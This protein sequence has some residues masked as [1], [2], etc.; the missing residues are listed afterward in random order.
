M[1][2]ILFTIL[3]ASILITSSA[4]AY[5]VKQGDT[6]SSIAEDF[7]TSWQS[8]W[9]SNPEIANPD[10]IFIGQN[11]NIPTEQTLG[12]SIPG[13]AALFE[14]SLQNSISSSATTMTLVSGTLKNSNTLSG[15][16]GFI[17]DEGS[18]NQEFVTATCSNTACTGMTRGI[19]PVTGD[20]AV[21]ALQSSH[22]RGA[23][24]KITDFPVLG[25]IRRI[26]NGDETLP[27]SLHAS[28]TTWLATN[29][30][31]LTTKYYVDN[32]GAGGFTNSNIGD[33]LTLRA[34][35]TSPETLDLNTTTDSLIAPSFT[36]ENGYLV[37]A[38]S[39]GS[40]IDNQI[41]DRM[42]ATTTKNLVFTFNDGFQ[43]NASSTIIGNF[44][45]DGN[46]TVTGQLNRLDFNDSSTTIVSSAAETT[47][48]TKSI[49]A[50]TLKT[51]NGVRLKGLITIGA[52]TGSPTLTLRLKY[53]GTTMVTIVI[54]KAAHTGD[55]GWIEANVFGDGSV[56]AQSAN[57]QYYYKE[58]TDDY[59]SWGN[60]S[61]TENSASD[62]NLVLTGQWNGSDPSN[63]ISFIH[64]SL[65]IIR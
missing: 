31:E 16:Y 48:Y 27:F 61:A 59:Y 8:I 23:S 43:S 13:V 41:S 52:T 65:E 38:T 34:N 22:R 40:R 44:R 1:K 17:I 56:S 6:L 37:N 9:H 11:I 29:N 2:K 20:D 21:S 24:V 55:K 35:G 32:V 60:G 54:T 25:V 57:I 39:T 64:P 14:T 47:L 28:S 51:F 33:G 62:L 42:N 7:N 36:I 49:P 45:V 5:T 10:L 50:N 15:F 19:D 58:T 3:L 4:N 26:L 53:G 18:A 63:S 12:A 30:D 46:L